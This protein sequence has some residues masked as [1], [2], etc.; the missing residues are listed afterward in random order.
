[1]GLCRK[2]QETQIS[3]TGVIGRLEKGINNMATSYELLEAMKKTNE[4]LKEIIKKTVEDNYIE[5]QSLA[6]TIEKLHRERSNLQREE[7]EILQ[8]KYEMADSNRKKLTV[9]QKE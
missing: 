5:K 9:C 3:D 7:A 8:K 6:E 2:D 1:M 4:E